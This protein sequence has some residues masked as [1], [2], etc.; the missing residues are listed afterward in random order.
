M[1]TQAE[2]ERQLKV[3]RLIF[4]TRCLNLALCVLMGIVAIL[5][6][7]TTP[8]AS[9]GI[10]SV[11]LLMFSCLLCCFEVHLKMV[12]VKIAKNFGFLFSP[13]GRIIFLIFIGVICFSFKSIIGYIGGGCMCVN[14]LFNGYVLYRYPEVYEVS[15]SALGVAY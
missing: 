13:I 6:L 3:P 1:Y 10:L 4:M 2:V 11:Y 5:E 14:A 7:L 12:S 15:P 9:A 8:S